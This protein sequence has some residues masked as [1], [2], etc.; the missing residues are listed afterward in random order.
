MGEAVC[1]VSR[2]LEERNCLFARG[3]EPSFALNRTL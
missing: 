2:E 3:E 1:V